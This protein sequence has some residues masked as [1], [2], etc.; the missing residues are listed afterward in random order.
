[1]LLSTMMLFYIKRNMTLTFWL[2]GCETVMSKGAAHIAR[3]L[4]GA[5]KARFVMTLF[6]LLFVHTS[7][8][9]VSRT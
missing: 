9:V 6:R 7:E 1:M 2:S 8:A 3:T 4:G 5:E